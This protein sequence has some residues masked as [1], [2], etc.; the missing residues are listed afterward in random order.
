MRFHHL[1]YL[2]RDTAQSV[3]A[4]KPFF[5]E[6]T[7][8]RQPH[9]LQRAY[10]TYM[11][12]SDGRVTLELVEPF[13]K[14]QLLAGRLNREKQRCIPY[15]ICLTVDDF[16]AEYHRLRQHG[17]LTL[18]R[19]FESLDSAAQVVHLYKP[20]A[21]IVEIMGRLSVGPLVLKE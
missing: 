1:A 3:E 7:L 15:H 2:V 14:N 9:E 5:P 4:L 10:I 21:G 11:S 17:W 13:E 8:L 6:L 16:E 12:T 18:T 19:P 20:A